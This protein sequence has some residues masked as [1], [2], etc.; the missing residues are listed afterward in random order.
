MIMP[1]VK[2]DKFNIR[3]DGHPVEA[4]FL[5]FGNSGSIIYKWFGIREREKQDPLYRKRF[6]RYPV[7]H[8]ESADSLDDIAEPFS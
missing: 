3:I 2:G 7:W 4:V 6:G 5:C 8:F 1:M